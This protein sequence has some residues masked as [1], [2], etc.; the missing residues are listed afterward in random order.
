MVH[1]ILHFQ[2]GLRWCRWC[3]FGDHTV[4][5]KMQKVMTTYVETQSPHDVSATLLGPLHYMVIE[6]L[7]NQEAVR[8]VIPILL[9]RNLR[10]SDTLFKVTE[11]LQ[12]SVSIIEQAK[13]RQRAHGLLIKF[14]FFL[15]KPCHHILTTR[16][17]QSLLTHRKGRKE[18]F[19]LFILWPRGVPLRNRLAWWQVKI[20]KSTW[21]VK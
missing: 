3:F 19:S 4:Y 17:I 14:R 13:C 7:N 15:Q 18:Q 12:L 5:S 1:E 11:T 21:S 20:G 2:H 10:G 16:K 8:I 6:V 9:E